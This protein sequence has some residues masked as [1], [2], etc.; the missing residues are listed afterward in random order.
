MNKHIYYEIFIKS[1]GSLSGNAWPLVPMQR[2]PLGHNPSQ[3]VCMHSFPSVIKSYIPVSH[4][5][6]ER[7]CTIPIMYYSITPSNTQIAPFAASRSPNT[8]IFPGFIYFSPDLIV[9]EIF[10]PLSVSSSISGWMGE[11]VMT[12]PATNCSTFCLALSSISW[13][14][15]SPFDPC[16]MT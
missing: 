1:F 4:Y 14:E 13:L 10:V 3:P 8:L 15:R 5:Y 11:F 9:Y 6:N 2:S 7:P 16:R 12:W